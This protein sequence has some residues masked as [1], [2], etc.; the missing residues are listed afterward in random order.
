MVGVLVYLLLNL[1]SI[2]THGSKTEIFA[3]IV[4]GFSQKAPS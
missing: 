4:D 3:K 1:N 2:Y